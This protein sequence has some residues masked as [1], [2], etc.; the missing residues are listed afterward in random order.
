MFPGEHHGEHDG[1]DY[2]HDRTG[3]AP[4]S[5]LLPLVHHIMPRHFRARQ[6][7]VATQQCTD[8]QGREHITAVPRC[9]ARNVLEPFQRTA[10]INSWCCAGCLQVPPTLAPCTQPSWLW[11]RPAA[12]Q[13]CW[14]LL[15]WV[16]CG[17]P[18]MLAALALGQALPVVAKP[19]CI[20]LACLQC[21]SSF[22]SPAVVG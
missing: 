16:R 17:T 9:P 20:C 4:P 7:V 18:G 12:P 1:E 8:V 3:T 19:E 5:A 2:G 22:H 14:Q 15:L 13:A 10:C 11:L 21:S 6:W